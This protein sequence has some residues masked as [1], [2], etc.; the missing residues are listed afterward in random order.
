MFK[1]I[2]LD[3]GASVDGQLIAQAVDYC[4]RADAKLTILN[5][6]EEPSASVSSYFSSHHKDLRKVILKSYE[7]M[8]STEIDKL[9]ID[10][11]NVDRDIRW[12]KDF[13]ETIKTVKKGNFDLVISASQNLEGPPDS[14]AMH[15]MRKCPCPVWIHRGNL[16]KGA[17]RIL[18]AINTSDSSEENQKL[19]RKILAHSLRLNEILRGHLHVVTCWSGYMESVLSSPR[20]TEKEKVEYLEFEQSQTQKALTT[21][22]EELSLT[23]AVKVK[24]FHGNP[25]AIIPQYAAEQ[26]MDIVVMGSVARTGIP[27]LLIGNTAEKIMSNLE[28]SIVAIKPDGFESPVK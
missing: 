19:N 24:I 13:I 1:K 12:G 21:I 22:S 8:V 25:A 10:L 27:G 23:D 3:L 26:K 17:I 14:T 15:L 2:L 11:S 20:F 9:K 7:T 4:E 18:A 28:N 16:W 6:F 5:V